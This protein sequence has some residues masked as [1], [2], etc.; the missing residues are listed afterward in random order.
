[1]IKSGHCMIGHD[2]KW[3]RPF[4]H[5]SASISNQWLSRGVIS[6]NNGL[7]FGSERLFAW[8]FMKVQSI[9]WV[10]FKTILLELPKI[11]DYSSHN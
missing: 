9:E 6:E 4:W 1:M 8:Q 5:K 11:G 2:W 7:D 10:K 3:T